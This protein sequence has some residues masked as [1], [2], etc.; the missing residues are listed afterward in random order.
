MAAAR[1]RH[2][3]CGHMPHAT[4]HMHTVAHSASRRRLYCV[5]CILWMTGAY[6]IRQAA[7]ACSLQGQPGATGRTGGDSCQ[8]YNR[9]NNT[10]D[11]PG[12]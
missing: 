6:T 12:R 4:C 9:G 11:N 8:L 3:M 10:P 1:M 5:Y 2:A 7:A